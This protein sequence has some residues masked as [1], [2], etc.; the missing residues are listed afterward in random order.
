MTII[1]YLHFPFVRY[2]FIVGILISLVSA[3]VGVPLVLKRYSYLGDGL[4]HIAFSATAIAVVANV[5]NNIYIVMPITIITA[6]LLL[7]PRRNS[8]IAGD[9]KIAAISV[10]SLALGYFLVNTYSSSSNVSGDVCASLFGSTSILTLTISD[11]ISCAVLAAVVLAVFVFFYNKIFAV[12]FD[13]NFVIAQGVK[14][15]A[16]EVILAVIIGIT[17]SLSMRLVGALLTSALIIFPALSA[18]AV[19]KTFKSVIICSGIFSVVCTTL[20]LVLSI[21]F[22]APV[23]ATIVLTDMIVFILFSLMKGRL[24][25]RKTLGSGAR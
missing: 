19:F 23:G 25:W 1:D 17:V 2:A 22:D 13:A 18:M 8:R 21:L 24:I 9:A 10:G 4:S 16:Y 5:S 7:V 3:V 15:A 6:I 12:T 14:G 11:V 20:G